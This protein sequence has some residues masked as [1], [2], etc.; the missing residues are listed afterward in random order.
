MNEEVDK[1]DNS[2]MIL[3]YLIFK[4]LFIILFRMLTFWYIF[5]KIIIIIIGAG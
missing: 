4:K 2:I 5:K 3:S 1:D